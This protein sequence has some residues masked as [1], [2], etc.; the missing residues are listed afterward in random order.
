MIAGWSPMPTS[1]P[2]SSASLSSS[3]PSPRPIRRSSCR[4]PNPLTPPSAHSACFRTSPA[5]PPPAHSPAPAPRQPAIPMN[6]VMGEDVLSPARVKGDFDRLGR[7]LTQTLSNQ[8][9]THTVSIHMGRDGLVI[10]LREAG[11]FASGS[12]APEAGN[13]P[14]PA[15]DCRFPRPDPL[16]PPR[17]GPHR[18]RAHPHLRIRLQLGAL[19]GPRHPHRP[20][21][22]RPQIHTPG[23]NLRRRIR[24]VPPRR[25]QLYARGPCR[26][27]PRRS[28]RP[29]P[30]QRRS[31]PAGP[32]SPHR[33][34]AQNH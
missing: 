8:V 22:S 6:I 18:Q 31:L 34:L 33:R 5:I 20:H 23:S 17:R 19:H 25:A 11:F 1:S 13:P 10:S 9:A 24:R 30:L 15:P 14:Y 32:R 26:K 2:C 27:P 4:S 12:A 7:E 3:L 28:G 21:P 16:R 29:A